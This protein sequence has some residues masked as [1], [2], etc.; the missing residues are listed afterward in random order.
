M[1]NQVIQGDC[2]EV[3]KTL[4]DKSIYYL[5]VTKEIQYSTLW[6]EVA[7][8]LKWQRRIIETI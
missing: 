6:Q 7:Q 1:K 2:L 4:D 8:H 3:M 5:G